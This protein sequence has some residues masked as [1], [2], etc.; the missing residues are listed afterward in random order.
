MENLPETI[1][2]QVNQGPNHAPN[3]DNQEINL[4]TRLLNDSLELKSLK[5]KASNELERESKRSLLN[6]SNISSGPL[7]SKSDIFNLS[8]L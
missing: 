1:D 8:L 5:R 6:D 4:I 7:L 2:K 3:Q